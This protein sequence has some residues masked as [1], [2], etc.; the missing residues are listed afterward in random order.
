M[1]GYIFTIKQ[2]YNNGVIE[3]D[4]MPIIT[5]T[6]EEAEDIVFRTYN[7]NKGIWDGIEFK[8]TT[9]M[10]KFFNTGFC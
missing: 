5:S 3:F 10:Q 7:K 2:Y 4:T 8:T 6:L 1:D 9:N